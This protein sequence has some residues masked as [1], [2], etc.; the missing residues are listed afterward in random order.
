[1]PRPGHAVHYIVSEFL[2]LFASPELTFGDVD[3]SWL[4][5]VTKTATSPGPREPR[6][7]PRKPAR[8]PT[9]VSFTRR[10]ARGLRRRAKAALAW[11]SVL[12]K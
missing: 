1:M 8:R 3:S 6:P 10:I 12:R 4:T 7:S 5:A 11:A 2:R 9:P